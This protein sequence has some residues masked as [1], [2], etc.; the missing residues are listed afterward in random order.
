MPTPLDAA[1]GALAHA[2]KAGQQSSAIDFLIEAVEI[3]VECQSDLAQR[4]LAL[5]PLQADAV[6]RHGSF[7][8]NVS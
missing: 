6:A 2:K 8:I 3:L 4:Q 5:I 7:G 1:R